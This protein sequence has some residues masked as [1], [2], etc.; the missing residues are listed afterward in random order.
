M[1]ILFSIGAITFLI[2]SYTFDYEE[3]RGVELVAA[4]AILFT[5]G[6]AAFVAGTC[7]VF[8]LYFGEHPP[9][10]EPLIA[11]EEQEE[12]SKDISNEIPSKDLTISSEISSTNDCSITPILSR[13]L[14]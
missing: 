12:V 3:G 1:D 11:P 9:R 14:P 5:V 10:K 7:L 4:T 8:V 2:G 6:S 13:T